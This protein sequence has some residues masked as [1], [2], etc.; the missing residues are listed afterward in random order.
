MKMQYGEFEGPAIEMGKF[1]KMLDKDTISRIR[2]SCD[3]AG[4]KLVDKNRSWKNQKRQFDFFGRDFC[5]P[6]S[7]IAIAGPSNLQYCIFVT[8][9]WE[10]VFNFFGRDF[11]HLIFPYCN[12][13]TLKFMILRLRLTFLR[14]K[15]F[16][17]CLTKM[18]YREFEG[19]K[20]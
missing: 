17:K 3:C 18:Q 15:K 12:R 8:H 16:Q 13:R 1:S 5:H 4:G 11:G 2:G 19:L 7:P 20:L 9:F 6:I 14:I 10:F